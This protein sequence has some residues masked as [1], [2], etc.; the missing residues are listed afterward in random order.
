M[1]SDSQMIDELSFHIILAHTRA[2]LMTF[3][4]LRPYKPHLVL[5]LLKLMQCYIKIIV[6]LFDAL[7]KSHFKR[8]HWISLM[9]AV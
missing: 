6:K 2:I 5:K 4:L 3:A 8:N 7:S 9:N 1:L